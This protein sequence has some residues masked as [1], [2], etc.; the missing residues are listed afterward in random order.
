MGADFYLFG[1]NRITPDG[2]RVSEWE[3][4]LMGDNDAEFSLMYE[5]GVRLHYDSLIT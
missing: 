4:D 5:G 3:N 1:D 2:R